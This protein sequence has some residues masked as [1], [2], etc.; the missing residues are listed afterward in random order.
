LT[1]PLTLKH[2]SQVVLLQQIK[3]IAL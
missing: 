3:E 2:K 1:H